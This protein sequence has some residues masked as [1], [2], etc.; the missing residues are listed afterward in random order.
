LVVDD[1]EGIRE[2]LRLVLEDAGYRV[3]EAAGGRDALAALQ[4]SAVPLVVLLDYLMPKFSGG[5]VL[6]VVVPDARLTT[7]HAYVL[8]TASPQMLPLDVAELVER[9]QAMILPKPFDMDALLDIV[10]KA[11]LH[12]SARAGASL[13]PSV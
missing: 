2:T 1:D 13:P 10:A 4:A 12:L 9:L 7:R 5:D 11:A 8:V 6:K 3:S